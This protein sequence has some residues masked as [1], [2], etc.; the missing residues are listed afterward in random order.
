[1]VDPILANRAKVNFERDML[2]KNPQ[3]LRQQAAALRPSDADV[4][5]GR[6]AG[7]ALGVFVDRVGVG[8]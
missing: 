2:V 3:Y 8:R 4:E 5:L 7:R 6:C 1:M